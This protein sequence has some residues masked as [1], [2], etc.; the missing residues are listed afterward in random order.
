[1]H[2]N[3]S[4]DEMTSEFD[5]VPF[6]GHSVT[7]WCLASRVAIGGNKKIFIKRFAERENERVT[8]R[9]ALFYLG[10]MMK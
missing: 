4:S 3:H 2:K 7:T 1:M 10:E 5:V 8:L 9:R 6:R